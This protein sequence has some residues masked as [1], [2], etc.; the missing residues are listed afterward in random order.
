MQD[1]SRN[2]LYPLWIFNKTVLCFILQNF[3]SNIWLWQY[4]FNIVI[5]HGTHPWKVNKKYYIYKKKLITGINFTHRGT[6]K[7]VKKANQA[8]FVC[9][10]EMESE[11]IPNFN[12]A[13]DVT[14]HNAKKAPLRRLGQ[15]NQ[16]LSDSK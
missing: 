1:N 11:V 5:S 2:W 13:N 15:I 6:S 12:K 7:S 14:V 9:Q 16:C 8:I 10:I 4:K 3:Y